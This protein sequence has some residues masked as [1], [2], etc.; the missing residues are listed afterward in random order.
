MAVSGYTDWESQRGNGGQ[1]KGKAT[2]GSTSL[3]MRFK[4]CLLRKKSVTPSIPNYS[5]RWRGTLMCNLCASR[6]SYRLQQ[7]FID[8]VQTSMYSL[9]ERIDHLATRE[10]VQEFVATSQHTS[11]VRAV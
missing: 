1:G 7:H 2:F 5:S 10:E 11:G 8:P 3:T 9:A 6:P 4:V